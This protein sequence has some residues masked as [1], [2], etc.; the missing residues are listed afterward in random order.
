MELCAA[1]SRH[2]QVWNELRVFRSPRIPQFDA[3]RQDIQ[4]LLIRHLGQQS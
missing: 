4:V 1:Q 2:T 3:L